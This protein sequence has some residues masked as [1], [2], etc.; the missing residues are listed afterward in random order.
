M[1]YELTLLTKEGEFMVHPGRELESRKSAEEWAKE[2]AEFLGVAGWGWW[3]KK[4]GVY[5]ATTERMNDERAY[6]LIRGVA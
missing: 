2:R 1:M 3:T 6:V 4:E 5:T